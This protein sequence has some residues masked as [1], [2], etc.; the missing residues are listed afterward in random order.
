MEPSLWTWVW[1]VKRVNV[2]VHQR[3]HACQAGREGLGLGWGACRAGLTVSS[4]ADSMQQHE[5]RVGY[6]AHQ[7][8]S[9]QKGLGRGERK[10]RGFL[11]IHPECEAH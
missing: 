11:P 9:F 4:H 8:C 10:T 5:V 3:L 1:G 2:G 7:A 6:L